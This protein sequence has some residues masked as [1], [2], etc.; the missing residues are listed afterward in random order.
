MHGVPAFVSWPCW[1]KVV[2]F[3]VMF[4]GSCI[5]AA[6][7]AHRQQFSLTGVTPEVTLDQSLRRQQAIGWS[8]G[9]ASLH[10]AKAAAGL[11]RGEGQ[12]DPRKQQ[13]TKYSR[14]QP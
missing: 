4:F 6:R 12:D 11:M 13:R 3:T 14:L 1:L 8:P 7:A 5:R 10:Y 2:T 9:W